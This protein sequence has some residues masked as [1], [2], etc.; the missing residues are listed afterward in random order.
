[1]GFRGVHECYPNS[2]PDT[3]RTPLIIDLLPLHRHQA[4]NSHM[5]SHR[6]FAS[7]QTSAVVREM[8]QES[9]LSLTTAGPNHKD[10]ADA[11]RW[12]QLCVTYVVVV[13]LLL[14]TT[15]VWLAYTKRMKW[16]KIEWTYLS[17][18]RGRCSALV[19][20]LFRAAFAIIVIS[21]NVGLYFQ[22]SDNPLFPGGW[23]IFAT[24]TVW[25]WTLIGVYM[26][27]AAFASLADVLKY[28]PTGLAAH[29][30]CCGM[31]VLFEVMVS[32]AV[33]ITICVWLVLLPAAYKFRGSDM[34]LLSFFPFASHNFNTAFMLFEAVTNRL[35]ITTPHLIFVFYYGAA[36]AIF[37]W[38]WY[39]RYHFFFYFF[40]DWRYAFAL[41]GYTLLL[42]SLALYFFVGRCLVNCI[43]PSAYSSKLFVDDL[44]GDDEGG[45]SDDVSGTDNDTDDEVPS[46]R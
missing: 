44:T 33:L 18:G 35:C 34:G 1:M 2:P 41:I 27:L 6:N 8:T 4:A 7:V 45:S 23:I 46:E 30:F 36:Y 12:Q 40:I 20:A 31:W 28:Q 21:V 24:F 42:S 13:L 15:H 10:P 5:Y 32:V 9:E 39:S 43:K 16:D 19:M 29:T 38:W 22:V 11:A 14:G 3:S 25:S 26:A 17:R 37:S